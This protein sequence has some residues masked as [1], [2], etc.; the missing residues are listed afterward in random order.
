MTSIQEVWTSEKQ[1][2]WCAQIDAYWNHIEKQNKRA[3]EEEMANLDL[4]LI[5]DSTDEA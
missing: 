1:P 4:Q 3:L 5:R 2:V